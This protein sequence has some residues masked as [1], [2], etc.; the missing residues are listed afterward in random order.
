ME[1]SK[2]A[3]IKLINEKKG[4]LDT[5][6]QNKFDLNIYRLFDGM[7]VTNA[8][9]RYAIFKDEEELINTLQSYKATENILSGKNIYGKAFPKYSMKL[10]DE[11]LIEFGLEAKRDTLDIKTLKKLDSLIQ[12]RPNSKQI[13]DKF[14]INFIAILGELLIQEEKAKWKVAKSKQ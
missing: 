4:K 14:F 10:I 5:I 9:E 8:H 3:A 6:F 1:I 11:L 2:Q 13:K 7:I 12:I